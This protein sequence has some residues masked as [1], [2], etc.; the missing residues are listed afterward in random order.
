MPP[1]PPPPNPPHLRAAT[2]TEPPGSGSP[3]SPPRF[4]KSL[5]KLS[6]EPGSAQSSSA[7]WRTPRWGPARGPPV[8]GLPRAIPPSSCSSGGATG[9]RE[10]DAGNASHCRVPLARSSLVPA[11]CLAGTVLSVAAS[12]AQRVWPCAA[13]PSPR[14][15]SKCSAA[16]ALLWYP[17]FA[18]RF[19][20]LPLALTLSRTAAA[21]AASPAPGEARSF[22]GLEL[23]LPLNSFTATP[24][25]HR[26]GNLPAGCLPRQISQRSP[27]GPA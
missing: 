7:V 27:R 22:A 4:L 10:G 5:S 1:H 21:S 18:S 12:R 19:R 14:A 17:D 11:A 2:R 20:R 3:P 8:R 6:P 15:A 26:A 13:S 9:G 23:C 16:A 24:R 25:C